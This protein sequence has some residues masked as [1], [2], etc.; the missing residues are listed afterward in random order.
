MVPVILVAGVVIAHLHQGDTAPAVR[1][2]RKRVVETIVAIGRVEPAA[3]ISLGPTEG[4]RVASV[5]VQEGDR[6]V[7][8]A[9]LVELDPAAAG[10]IRAGAGADVRAA[11]VALRQ[12]TGL[13]HPGARDRLARAEVELETARRDHERVAR[14]AEAGA[15]PRVDLEAAVLRLARAR[16]ELEHATRAVRSAGKNGLSRRAAESDLARAEAALQDAQRLVDARRLVAP[17]DGI[18][19]DRLVEPGDVVA[20]G[21]TMLTLA[22]SGPLRVVVEPDE[23]S[24]ARLARGQAATVVTEARPD[25]SL[26]AVVDW[27]APRVDADRGTI[28]V[29]LALIDPPSWLA[30]DMTVSVEIV[31]GVVDAAITVPAVVVRDATTDPWVSRRRGDT[32]ERVPVE[33]GLRGQ[34]VV[35]IRHGVDEGDELLLPESAGG[36]KKVHPWD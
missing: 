30:L 13:E 6:V 31:T 3:T 7:A 2:E 19:L 34:D 12:V 15:A 18:V 28:E 1:A 33:L 11:T 22:R 17:A 21:Q 36:R 16:E 32:V 8:G 27:I 29:R 20:P 4:G 9:V 23:R 26:G 24:L 35:E 25:I 5:L 10:A 14:L